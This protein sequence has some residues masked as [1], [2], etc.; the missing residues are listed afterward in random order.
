VILAILPVRFGLAL[1]NEYRYSY[2][3]E[4]E[5]ARARDR[6]QDLGSDGLQSTSTTE[7]SV[8]FYRYN[9]YLETFWP[10]FALKTTITFLLETPQKDFSL[11]TDKPSCAMSFVVAVYVVLLEVLHALHTVGTY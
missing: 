4:M 2:Y 7:Y 10:R 5:H 3:S 8:L 1:G 6:A 11:D 9:S